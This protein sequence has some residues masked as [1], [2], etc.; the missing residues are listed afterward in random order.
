[1]YV[2]T[3]GNIGIKNM[4]NNDC[5][6]Q[7]TVKQVFKG[8]GELWTDG[9][10]YGIRDLSSKRLTCLEDMLPTMNYGSTFKYKITI[11]IEEIPREP[12]KE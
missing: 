11:I 12:N 6:K 8:I 9:N 7:K 5:E 4:K 3:G 1:M 2:S 10:V